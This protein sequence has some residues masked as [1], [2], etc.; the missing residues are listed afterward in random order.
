MKQTLR[1]FG[2]DGFIFSLFAAILLAWVYPTVG[3]HRGWF[4]LATGANLGVSLIFFFYGLRLNWEKIYEGL[5]NV[6]MH[7]VVLLS[8]F[9]LFPVLVLSAMAV[10]NAIPTTQAIA[11]LERDVDQAESENETNDQEAVAELNLDVS[12]TTTGL[13]LGVFFL[14]TLPSTVSSSVVMTNVA[15]GN[16]PAA[17]FDASISS[18]LGVF[19]TPL[20]MRIFITAETGGRE[21]N[22]VLI[23]LV[24][25]VLIPIALGIL[26]NRRWGEFSRRNAN[27]LRRFDQSVIVLIVYVSFCSSFKQDMFSGLSF[28]KL[29]ILTLGTIGLFFTV[30]GIIAAVCKF[31]RFN[32][33]DSIATLF[34]GSK[35]SLV[36][37]AVM[38]RV[39]LTDPT[40]AGVLLLPTMIYHAMQLVVVSILAQ[41]FGRQYDKQTTTQ[42]KQG[43]S[44][45]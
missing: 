13:L 39:I 17:I 8:T 15:R 44:N 34:C 31:L 27:K 45:D 21:F 43:V 38:S 30:Y 19:F 4:S 24:F 18:L 29:T 42:N 3:A 33:E 22:A 37:G 36:H 5:R 25:Q 1:R 35:K 9:L 26:A 14:A 7:V 10:F 41:R 12:S 20:W 23:K 40:M 11:A 32:R 16:V 2:I 28:R 6:K